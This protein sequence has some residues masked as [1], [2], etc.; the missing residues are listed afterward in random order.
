MHLL[1]DNNAGTAVVDGKTQPAKK[2]WRAG[3][4]LPIQVKK[5]EAPSKPKPAIRPGA[6]PYRPRVGGAAK[7]ASSASKL[8]SADGTPS[9]PSSSGEAAGVR[10]EPS[11]LLNHTEKTVAEKSFPN[12]PVPPGLH[13]GEGHKCQ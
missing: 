12:G 9:P 11:L 7:D 2:G 8:N 6:E 4:G 13:P 1:I 3:E 5:E 10:P